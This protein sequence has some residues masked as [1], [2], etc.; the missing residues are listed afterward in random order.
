[1]QYKKGRD[2]AYSMGRLFH[3]DR[4]IKYQLWDGDI[5]VAEKYK[6]SKQK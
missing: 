6:N 1:M 5:F 4:E 2:V 3:I